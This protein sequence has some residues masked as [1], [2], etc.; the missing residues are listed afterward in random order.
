[1]ALDRKELMQTLRYMGEIFRQLCKVKN[2]HEAK[3]YYEEARSLSVKNHMTEEESAEIFGVRGERGVILRV[4]AFP[5]EMV[6]E[7]YEWTVVRCK[8]QTKTE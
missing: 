7:M 5:E 2:Y 4:G 3:K 8:M 6:I 1:M